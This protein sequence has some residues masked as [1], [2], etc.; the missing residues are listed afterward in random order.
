MIVVDCFEKELPDPISDRDIP[1]KL[2][3]YLFIPAFISG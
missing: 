1:A 3:I 2:S